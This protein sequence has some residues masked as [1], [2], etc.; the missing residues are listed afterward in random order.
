MIL[1]VQYFII[2]C[3]AFE[4][5]RLRKTSL[6]ITLS[7]YSVKSSLSWFLAINPLKPCRIISLGPVTTSKLT[8]QQPAF[9]A[10]IRAIGN[11]STRDDKQNISERCINS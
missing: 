7:R 5:K 11:P 2:D 3:G 4:A 10:S 6:L 9:I 1:S 8:Q